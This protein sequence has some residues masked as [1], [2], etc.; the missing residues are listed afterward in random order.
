MT[1]KRQF[2]D[3]IGSG[4]RLILLKFSEPNTKIRIF[5]HAIQLTQESKLE[6]YVYRPLWR[7]SRDDMCAIYPM[8]VRF[9]EL[10]LLEKKKNII[11]H[12]SIEDEVE[13][14]FLIN[15]RDD[16]ST[17]SKKILKVSMRS[18]IQGVSDSQ[19]SEKCYECLKKI[20]QYISVGLST[21]GETYGVD[22][23]T[24]T[25]QYYISLL[26]H[27]ING[28]YSSDKLPSHLRDFSAHNLLDIEKIKKLWSDSDIINMCDLFD[29][30]FNAHKNNDKRMVRAEIAA[31][32]D[33]LDARDKEFREIVESTNN[34]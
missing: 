24:M 21:L 25:L 31:I 12:S 6:R 26:D 17:V 22:N 13:N 23:A 14:S 11:P 33:I 10:Y 28:T 2:L 20:A 15:M 3:P 19:Y 1:S 32:T 18:N 9:I 34:A 29:R 16:E 5:N 7:D 8:I 27:G 4:C 30:C